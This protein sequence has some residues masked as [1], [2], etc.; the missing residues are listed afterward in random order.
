MHPKLSKYFV[1]KIVHI[2]AK[3][4]YLNERVD[5]T[6]G[7][8]HEKAK[9]KLAETEKQII[10]L[11]PKIVKMLEKPDELIGTLKELVKTE[12]ATFPNGVVFQAAFAKPYIEEFIC[13]VLFDL[14]MKKAISNNN[15]TALKKAYL[16]EKI[17]ID[18]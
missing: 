11:M 3:K 8:N 12:E 4:S 18:I 13:I 5:F 15:L 14:K 6:K 1:R 9:K 17:K 7:D 2:Y 16:K 10:E